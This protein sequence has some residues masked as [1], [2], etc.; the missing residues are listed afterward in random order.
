MSVVYIL[1]SCALIG[2]MALAAGWDIRA[3]RI[4]NWLTIT[5]LAAGIALRAALGVGAAGDGLAGAGVALLVGLLLF[6]LG[7]FG[8]GDA[9]LLAVVGAF[10]GL[11]GL[12]EAGLLIA[13]LGGLFAVVDGVR[14]GV[15]LPLLM[16]SWS[17]VKA[18]GTLGRAGSTR[19]LQ[20]P[21][22]EAIPYGVPI[23]VGAVVSW[24]AEVP[25]L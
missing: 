10:V 16:N 9:K 11:G 18:W 5:G 8:G 24:F 23:A 4:P 13:L 25:G 3:R 19:T 6:A 17:M 22:A 20:T 12:L 2:V 14:R 7:A 1:Q 21:G 15:I